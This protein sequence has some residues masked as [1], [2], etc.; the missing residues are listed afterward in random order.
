M[1]IEFGG[2]S[3][4]TSKGFINYAINMLKDTLA[5]FYRL[6]VLHYY[7]YNNRKNWITPRYLTLVEKK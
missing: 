1:K 5:V 3:V 2:A 6:K 4:L 7:D